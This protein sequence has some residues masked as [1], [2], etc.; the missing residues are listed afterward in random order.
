V[1]GKTGTVK[2]AGARGYTEKNYFAVFAG[3]AP[4]DK[5]RL[6]IVVM[7]DEPSAGQY[8]GGLVSAPVFSKV[9]AG[10]LRVLD[11]APDQES[12]MPILLTRQDL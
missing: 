8:Y 6:I 12:T 10:A 4:A 3:M 11:I 5:P 9:M 2:K 1:A 7:I